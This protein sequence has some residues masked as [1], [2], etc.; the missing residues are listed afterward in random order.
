VFSTMLAGGG[1][2][3]GVIHGASD[4]LGGEPEED[5]VT[6]ADFAKTIYHQLG[7]HSDKELMAPGGRPIEIVNG[8]S[9]IKGILS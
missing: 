8:G 5:K 2:K 7:I 1:I 3:G 4:A 6:V 9:L